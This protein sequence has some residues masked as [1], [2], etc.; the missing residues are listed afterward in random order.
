MIFKSWVMTNYTTNLLFKTFHGHAI[1]QL[2]LSFKALFFNHIW[3]ESQSITLNI[4]A[5]L[6]CIICTCSENN[7]NHYFRQTFSFIQIRFASKSDFD[8]F[9]FQIRLIQY[10]TNELYCRINFILVISIIVPRII[11]NSVLVFLFSL[12]LPNMQLLLFL[13]LSHIHEETL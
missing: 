4:Q 1:R 2:I 10:I 8:I 3:Y 11:M 13:P 7:L 12:L 6:S 9:F 5:S